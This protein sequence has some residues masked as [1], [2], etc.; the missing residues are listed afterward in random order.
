MADC[1]TRHWTVTQPIKSPA[2]LE[3]EQYLF[4]LPWFNDQYFVWRAIRFNRWYLFAA[5]FL[6]QFCCGSVYAWSIYNTPMDTYLFGNGAD[7]RSP[8]TFYIAIGTLGST[9]AV[10]GP[11]LERHGPR[12]GMF[13]GATMFFLGHLTTAV[14]LYYKSIVGVYVGY[15][16]IGGFGIGINYISPVSALQKWFPDMRGTAAGFA[17]AGFG[18]GSTVWGK[19]YLP[20][21]KLFG[22]PGNFVVLGAIMAAI[23]Y[24]CT[25]VM[26]TPP[27]GFEVAGINVHGLRQDDGI[28]PYAKSEDAAARDVQVQTQYAHVKAMQL[29]DCLLNIDYGFMYVMLFGN[30]VFGLVLLGRLSTMATGLFGQ[31]ANEGTNVVAING[32]F[33]CVGRLFWPLVSDVLVRG[34]KL[35]PPFAR[36]LVFLMTLGLQLVLI[37]SMEL[38]IRTKNYDAFRAQ[39]WLLTLCLGGGFGT[40][41][42]F[43]TDMFGAYNIGAVHGVILTA[44]SLAGV[45][46]GLGFTFYYNTLTHAS[47]PVSVQDA[48]LRNIHW[49]V[50]ITLAGFLATFCVRSRGEDRFAAD[51]KYQY[52]VC[53]KPVIRIGRQA[54]HEN[55]PEASAVVA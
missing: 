17:V 30:I 9:A 31:T 24:G 22:L 4:C 54:R 53:G 7:G 35:N 45:V 51:C 48:Y 49:I 23:M 28:A 55:T 52:S 37:Y 36:K 34:F 16:L 3:A 44:W 11:W 40:I 15:G 33:N 1:L 41:P 14:A 20:A 32:V 13:L 21:A 25:I 19:V 50:L 39:I 27:P 46:G 26:R 42:A 8:Y 18:A 43:L 47:P 12:R 29:R 10:L 6:C 2:Q 5:S 38:V